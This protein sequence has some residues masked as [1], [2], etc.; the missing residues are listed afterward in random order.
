MAGKSRMHSASCFACA[1]IGAGF[2][3]I[4]SNLAGMPNAAAQSGSS[5]SLRVDVDLVTI[6]VIALDK[7]GK[8]VRNLKK[9][10]FQLYEDG[11]KQ[12]IL[13]FDE[14][15]GDSRIS[16]LGIT[17]LIESGL[18]RGKTVLILFDDSTIPQRIHRKIARFR[19]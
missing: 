5:F 6:E 10:D 14:V 2:Q 19:R 11:K 17:P 16:S 7:K 12:E 15:N 13:S 1:L 3:F 4:G 8:P 9:E 18:H